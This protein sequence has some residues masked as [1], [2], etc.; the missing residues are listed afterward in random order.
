MSA[1]SEAPRTDHTRD[2]TVHCVQYHVLIRSLCALTEIYHDAVATESEN[3]VYT[4]TRLPS[5]R[6][7]RPVESEYGVKSILGRKQ[8]R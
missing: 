4:Y 1:R 2:V 3:A 6:V 7:H 5:P 8:R